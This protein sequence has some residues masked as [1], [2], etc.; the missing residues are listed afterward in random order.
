MKRCCKAQTCILHSPTEV[1]PQSLEIRE[2]HCLLSGQ[3]APKEE[4]HSSDS[5][6]SALADGMSQS[7]VSSCTQHNLMICPPYRLQNK[8][9]STIAL[10]GCASLSLSTLIVAIQINNNQ[11]NME[12]MGAFW[13]FSPN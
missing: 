13:S 9:W 12:I 4:I 3:N 11:G 8:L 1:V 6:V 5:C 7:L 10:C 2:N